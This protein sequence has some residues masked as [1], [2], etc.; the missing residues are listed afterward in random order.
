MTNS[1]EPPRGTGRCLCGGVTYEVRG[2]LRNVVA[3]HC[4]ECRRSSGSFW[5]ATGARR[6]DLTII[7]DGLLK[8]YG[9]SPGIRRGF[10]GGCGASLFWDSKERSFMAIAAGSLDKPTGLNLV[11]H[12]FTAEAGDYYKIADRLPAFPEGNHGVVFPPL[13]S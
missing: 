8:W 4:D 13:G 7:E 6:E 10:C 12:I 9:S 5:A 3:C 2:P 1:D 11:A